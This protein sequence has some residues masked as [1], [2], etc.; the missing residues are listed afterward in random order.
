MSRFLITGLRF[1]IALRIRKKAAALGFTLVEILVAMFVILIAVGG[2]T[3]LFVS[4][5]QYDR[6]I[7]SKFNLQQEAN[8][9]LFLTRQ[10]VFNIGGRDL[11]PWHLVNLENNC[12]ARDYFAACAGS[13]RLTFGFVDFDVSTLASLP[14]YLI[15]NYTAATKIVDVAPDG[16]G[17]CQLT[18]SI[19]NQHLALR[20]G[21]KILVGWAQSIDVSACQ[22]QLVDDVQGGILTTDATDTYVG[23]SINPIVVATVFLDN[24]LVSGVP[25][26]QLLLLTDRS[27][28]STTSMAANDLQI[29][30]RGVYDFQAALGYDVD[31]N[32]VV[33]DAN[34][35]VDEVL[36]NSA[37]DTFATLGGIGAQVTDL[38]SVDI[39]VVMAQSNNSG[40]PSK[41]V[42]L[43]DGAAVTVPSS[44]IVG[45]KRRVFLRN[46]NLFM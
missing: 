39:G 26:R 42:Q 14:S 30:A 46:I 37:G 36:F 38:R 22:I 44:D 41:S 10:Y 20:N 27:N 7:D 1:F 19:Q 29:L 17:V 45:V 31:K 23:G 40:L 32:T 8:L 35:A 4:F 33:D 3:N 28:S 16:F 15:V 34:S 13:D 11:R 12:G 18:A 25:K 21:D 9:A 43:F 5:V 6:K 2:A 24:S